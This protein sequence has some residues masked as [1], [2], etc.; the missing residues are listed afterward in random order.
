VDG[1]DDEAMAAK[2]SEAAAASIDCAAN[3]GV[4]FDQG[5]TEA[6]IFRPRKT[7]P[8]A[9]VKGGANTVPFNKEAARWLGIWLDSQLTLRDHHDIRLKDGKRAMAR[10]PP[11]CRADGTVTGKLPQG[12]GGMRSVSGHVRTG[13]VVEGR[14]HTGLHNVELL[15]AAPAWRADGSNTAATATAATL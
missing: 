8:M 1:A 2:L 15:L 3:N 7:A 12:H 9:T 13:A 4:P 5:K 11:G 6:A 10:L 14:P